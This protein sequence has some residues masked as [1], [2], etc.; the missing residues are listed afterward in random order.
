MA[1]AEEKRYRGSVA[2]RGC[3]VC[4]RL[5]YDVDDTPALIH[6]QIHGRGGWGKASEYRTIGLCPHHHA[7][8]KEGVHALNAEL[9]YDMYGFS[10][11][12]LIE[13]TQRAL[14]KHVP[15]HER[16]FDG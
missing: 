5:G 4:R 2:R 9:F 8:S 10:E 6:H 16:V 1:T 13:E 3:C 12:E 14:L 7:D 15:T 11:M